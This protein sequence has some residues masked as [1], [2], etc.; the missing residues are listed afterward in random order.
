MTDQALLIVLAVLGVCGILCFAIVAAV[1]VEERLEYYSRIKKAGWTE[2]ND[3]R[4]CRSQ[5]QGN[6][7]NSVSQWM[8]LAEDYGSR[9]DASFLWLVLGFF[10]R[11]Y[12]FFRIQRQARKQSKIYSPNQIQFLESIQSSNMSATELNE[13]LEME[14]GKVS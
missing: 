1:K 11:I 10:I 7:F 14:F 9:P 13:K 3:G 4:L 12:L 5:F 2:D 8:E 6:N